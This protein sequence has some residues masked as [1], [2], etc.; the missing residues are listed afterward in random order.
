MVFKLHRFFL[1]LIV[2]NLK[3]YLNIKFSRFHMNKN[4]FWNF[5]FIWI[6]LFF[7]VHE[8]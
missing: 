1:S 6:K 2:K 7:E 5:F 8:I 4:T 3:K